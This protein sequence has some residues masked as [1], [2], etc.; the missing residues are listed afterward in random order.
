M[1]NQSTPPFGGF[2]PPGVGRRLAHYW[3]LFAGLGAANLVAG[4][5]SVVLP[6]VTV[7]VLA[8]LVGLLL[9]VTG[10][11]AVGFGLRLRRSGLPGSWAIVLGGLTMLV[12]VVILSQPNRGVH[13]IVVACGL[14]FIATGLGALLIVR[15]TRHRESTVFSAVLGALSVVIGTVVLGYFSVD[16]DLLSVVIGFGFIVRGVAEVTLALRMRSLLRLGF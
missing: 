4:L 16:A 8:L 2:R 14:W 12:G 7:L 13:A 15:Q 11:G 1:V 9:A 5:I 10:A 6:G 3:R